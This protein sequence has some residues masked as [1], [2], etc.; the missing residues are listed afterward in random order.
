MPSQ[1]PEVIQM[2]Q[3]LQES[4]LGNLGS[5]ESE[6]AAHLA[7]EPAPHSRRVRTKSDP[8]AHLG[9]GPRIIVA[10]ISHPRR[11]PV[12]PTW[13]VL[14]DTS[15]VAERSETAD[16][17]KHIQRQ[18][19]SNPPSFIPARNQFLN[20]AP[21]LL[22][23][24]PTLGP[25]EVVHATGS[26]PRS[27]SWCD[28]THRA[29]VAPN[30]EENRLMR[31]PGGFRRQYLHTRADAEGLPSEQRPRA[32]GSTFLGNQFPS[33]YLHS[34]VNEQIAEQRFGLTSFE[35]ATFTGV[36]VHHSRSSAGGGGMSARETAVT[37]FKGNCG[38]GILYMPGA[39]L[40][41]GWVLGIVVILIMA[42]VSTFC[43]L[44]LLQ[45]REGNSYSYGDLM[46]Q[47]S[48]VKGRVVV[49]IS[50]VLLQSGICC[51]YFINFANI[52]QNTIFPSVSINIIIL[53]CVLFVG[54]LALVRKVS[55]LGPLML[56]SSTLMIVGLLTVLALLVRNIF[57]HDVDIRALNP[58]NP[59]RALVFL[60]TACFCF[61][62]IGLVIPTYD[63]CAVQ[64]K[65][66]II[67]ASVIGGIVAIIW[68]VGMLGYLAFG[69]LTQ[70]LVLLNFPPG[71][72]VTVLQLAFGIAMLLT[73][74]LQLLPGI[75][76]LENTIL[77]PS[78]Q[79]TWDKHIKNAFRLG[80]AVFLAF[81]AIAGATSLDNF[82]SV[83]GAF[84]GVP[85]A[86]VFPSFVHCKFVA[87]R[88]SLSSFVDIGLCIVGLTLAVLVSYH[89]LMNWGVA[90]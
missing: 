86:F 25:A 42:M 4:M 1:S 29:Q 5:A 10:D 34:V 60:G 56:L 23:L 77:P 12:P 57:E 58:V 37:I 50:I 9:S 62:G 26:V 40:D 31:S 71:I 66:G 24:P 28:A 44:R 59:S 27:S 54:P 90:S 38:P 70:T 3:E 46:E 79:G 75:R 53:A 8:A 13:D 6:P 7:E 88:G 21:T 49:S 61:E 35:T 41:G 32:W 18:T 73:F 83:I 20:P 65:F 72:L 68:A 47:V 30:S 89:N 81:V 74:P 43:A 19:G 82:V 52:L 87:V 55:K 45:C 48:G 64:D 63:N 15:N 67:Y 80:Y 36:P 11:L 17:I 78:R 51:S 84:C 76:I 16:I 2:R 22:S 85:L 69:K 33:I 14:V 39:F